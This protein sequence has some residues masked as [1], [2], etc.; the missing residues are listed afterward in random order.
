MSEA[1]TAGARTPVTLVLR[2]PARLAA[3][4]EDSLLSI[5]A[6]SPAPDRVL[7]APDGLG[8][9][10]ARGLAEL[11][12]DFRPLLPDSAVQFVHDP[13]FER[14][15]E[16]LAAEEGVAGV[17][18]SGDVLFGHWCRTVRLA[19]AWQPGA[20]LV[21]MRFARQPTRLEQ[22]PSG[23]APFATAGPVRPYANHY[24]PARHREH[25]QTPASAVA[26]RTEAAAG[27]AGG[28]EDPRDVVWRVL[29]RAAA[30]P[31]VER[32]E[33]TS[34]VRAWDEAEWRAFEHDAMEPGAV[35]AA[36]GRARRARERLRR[37]LRR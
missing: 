36:P 20:R 15:V 26:W 21:R 37:L 23:P 30:G 10:T 17:L 11:A 32:P 31:I 1:A 2:V 5:A 9:E 12:R 33:I 8:D 14:T 22:G 19:L 7:I 24:D 27:L 16:R 34:L 28:G 4:A 29:E 35:V 3:V 25:M 13:R 18:R 6:Q